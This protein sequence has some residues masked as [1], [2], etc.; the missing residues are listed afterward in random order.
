[1]AIESAP[2]LALVAIANYIEQDFAEGGVQRSI[3]ERAGTGLSVECGGGGVGT[4][5]PPQAMRALR[6]S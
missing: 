2:V 1:M 6:G 4:V 5:H 3:E